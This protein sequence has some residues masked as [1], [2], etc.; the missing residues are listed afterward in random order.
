[1]KPIVVAKLRV[2]SVTGSTCY[3]GEGGFSGLSPMWPP[4]TP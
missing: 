1:M 2:E 3:A 4:M